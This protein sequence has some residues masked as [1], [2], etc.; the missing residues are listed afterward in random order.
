MRRPAYGAKRRPTMHLS[1]IDSLPKPI[2]TGDF[3]AVRRLVSASGTKAV[4]LDDDPTGTQT[5]HGVDVLADWSVDALAAALA[6]PRPCFFVLTN[7]RS[8]PAAQAAALVARICANLSA[9]GKAAGVDFV[10]ISR[11]DSTLRGHFAAELGAL[12]AGLQGAVDATIVIPAFFEG[13]R[14]TIGNVHYVADGERLVPAADTEFARDKTFGYVNSDLRRWIEEK[15]GGTVAANAV[16]DIDIE[17]L[18]GKNAAAQVRSR[19]L[20]LPKGAFLVVNAAA[21]SD[22]EAFTHGLLEAEAL[23][24]RYLFRTAASFVRVRAGLEPRPL[25]GASDMSGAG[26]EGGLI[27]VGSYVSKTTVQLES[28]LGLPDV[29]GIEVDVGRLAE[30]ATGADEIRRAAQAAAGAIGRGRHAAVFTSRARTSAVGPV[31]DLRAGRIVSDALVEIVRQMPM[32]PRFLIAKGGITSSDIAIHGLGMRKARVLGQAVPGVPVW[33][34]GEET[35]F[36]GMKLVVWPGNV[37]GPD[38]LRDLVRRV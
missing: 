7:S 24:R 2:D 37:G 21:Y 23:G 25:L 17:T 15:T 35:R 26:A 14:Y 1:I 8:L 30:P 32:R 36:P 19:L 28:L 11:G 3:A 13:G 31:G 38:A 18:R 16:A 12:E 9:A 4:V 27:V 6:D 22:L 20:K 10:V 33:E 29:D 5:V 34:M